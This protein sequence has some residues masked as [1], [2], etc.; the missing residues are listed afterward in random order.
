MKPYYEQDGISIYH[1]D[2]ISVLP[3]LPKSDFA[4]TD[5]P[6]AVRDDEW[7]VFED[8]HEFAYFTGRWLAMCYS[9]CPVVACFFP[10]KFVPLLREAAARRSIPYRRALV[11]RKPPGSQ[12]AGASLDGFWYDFEMIQVFGQPKTSV[13]KAQHFGVIEA[14]TVAGQS[15]GC[16][17]PVKL[18]QRLIEAYTEP[19]GTV[20]DP[21]CGTGTTL[22]AAKR[23]GRAAIGIEQSEEHCET[24]CQRLHQAVLPL[25]CDPRPVL[26]TPQ[27]HAQLFGAETEAV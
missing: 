22:V 11:W 13:R 10:D 12:Y 16:E 23:V 18:L 9:L 15:H 27:A 3:H 8:E 17:K 2:C 1:G 26:L 5:P 21:F 6:F 19:G 24:A 4:L 20:I 14:R 25:E 7:D